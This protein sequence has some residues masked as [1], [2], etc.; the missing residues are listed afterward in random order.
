MCGAR[1]GGGL[2]A[3]GHAVVAHD[4]GDPQPVVGEHASAAL[5]LAFAVLRLVTPAVTASSSRQNDSDRSLPASVKLW[6]RSTEIK[7]SICSSSA[8]KVA[9]IAR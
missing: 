1:V 5:G 4:G 8:R 7:P 2:R 3:L 9:A 6:K